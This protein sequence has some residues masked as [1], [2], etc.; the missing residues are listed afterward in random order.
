MI[1]LG[2]GIAG[3]VVAFIIFAELYSIKSILVKQ[4][5]VRYDREELSNEIRSLKIKSEQ[6]SEAIKDLIEIIEEGKI[7]LTEYGKATVKRVTALAKENSS[8]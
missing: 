4:E 7:P 5:Q 2:L 3:L 8:E 1:D 6:Q